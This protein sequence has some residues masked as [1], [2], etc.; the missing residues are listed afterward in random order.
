MQK[1]NYKEKILF[2]ENISELLL[3]NIDE[4]LSKIEESDFFRINGEIQISGEVKSEEKNINFNHPIEVDIM[5]SKEQAI[6]EEINISLDDF[7]YLIRD[8][9]IDI[10]LIMKIDGLKEIEAYFPAQEDKEDAQIEKV[11]EQ[12]IVEI[13]ENEEIVEEKESYQETIEEIVENEPLYQESIQETI[14]KERNTSLLNQIFRNKTFKK[15]TSH[16][17]HVVK[18]ETNYQE[19]ASLY[20]IDIDKLKKINNDEEIYIGKLI[21]IPKD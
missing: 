4:K 3:I 2:K 11:N 21:L 6:S 12:R 17:F 10:N 13:Q 7:N 1:I 20:G 9:S 8:N 18:T 15:D 16:L 14:D 5:L 19:I